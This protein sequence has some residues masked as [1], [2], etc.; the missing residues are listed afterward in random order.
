MG[1]TGTERLWSVEVTCWS[2]LNTVLPSLCVPH[3]TLAKA[4]EV[5]WQLT[6]YFLCLLLPTPLHE[7]EDARGRWEMP[8]LGQ[9]LTC[10][11]G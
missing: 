11:M 4:K 3:S 7:I 8:A 1:R 6:F 2:R 10:R 9:R 5:L